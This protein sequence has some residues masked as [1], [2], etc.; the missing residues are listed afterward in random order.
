[1]N[2]FKLNFDEEL[3]KEQ[4]DFLYNGEVPEDHDEMDYVKLNLKGVRLG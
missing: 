2:D 1:M 3:A 4:P